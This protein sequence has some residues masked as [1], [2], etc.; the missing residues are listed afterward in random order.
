MHKSRGFTLVEL[1][2]V[3]AIIALLIGLLLPALA[4]ARRSAQ[5]TKDSSQIN[6]THKGLLIYANS[7][8]KNQLPIPG[9]IWGIPQTD[10]NGAPVLG[11]PGQERGRVNNHHNLWSTAI[12]QEFFGPEILYGPTEVNEVVVLDDDYDYEMYRPAAGTFWD[13]SFTADI[14]GTQAGHSDDA[15]QF[16]G[17]A[18]PDE[19]CNASYAAMAI[20]A[21][22]IGGSGE[23]NR[24]RD[25]FWVNYGA[26]TVVVLGTRG[27]NRGI[28]NT[29]RYEKSPTLQL[30]GDDKSWAGNFCFADN[31]MESVKT[32]FPNQYMCED[33]GGNVIDN[34]FDFE[35]GNCGDGSAHM[36]A[37]SW[38]GMCVKANP[39]SS[40]GAGSI[41]VMKSDTL[42]P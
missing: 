34:V 3:I 15:T 26:P 21:P 9:K 42:L 17:N 2:V 27:T 19:Q 32:F 6:Q 8:K 23:S 33:A 14:S 36:Q 4:K 1:L 37:D 35:F 5:S 13:P 25:R 41:S 18:R 31:H 22:N 12:A 40:S 11:R 30:H 29:T 20:H 28:E 7:D 24:R 38:I 16:G 39:A 10:I